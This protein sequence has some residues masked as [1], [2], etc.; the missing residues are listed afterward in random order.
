MLGFVASSRI[1]FAYA[2]LILGIFVYKRSG[3]KKITYLLLAAGITLIFHL[4]FY[5]WSPSFYSP[6]HIFFKA[7]KFMNE[8]LKI[9]TIVLSLAAFVLACLKS[10]YSLT[11]WLFF[12]FL[13]LGIPLLFISA[14]DLSNFCSFKFSQWEGANYFMI[15]LPIYLSYFVLKV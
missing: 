6:V 4:S 8:W 10:R 13:S 2:I 11:S 7:G 1:V 3:L 9:I 15:V 12:L 14:G 5:L